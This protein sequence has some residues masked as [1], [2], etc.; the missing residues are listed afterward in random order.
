M[1]GLH[2]VARRA[3]RRRKKDA[4][5]AATA[6]PAVARSSPHRY[7]QTLS[8]AQGSNATNGTRVIKLRPTL[9]A[10]SAI[11]RN[12]VMGGNLAALSLL[13][14]PRSLLF[15]AS[16]NLFLL[17]AIAGRR[18]VTESNVFDVLGGGDSQQITLA[19]LQGE[20]WLKAVST[21]A[22]DLISLCLICRAIEPRVV[23]EIG[24]LHGYTAL[25]F[26]L[27]TPDDTIVHTLDLPQDYAVRPALT[28]T[29]MDDAHIRAGTR[30]RRRVFEGTSAEAKVVPLYGDSAAFDFSPYHGGVYFFF[31]DGAHSYEYVAADTRNAFACVRAGGVIAWHDFGRVGVNGVSRLVREVARS[32]EVH[33]VPG[34]S[35]AFT[36]V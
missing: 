2:E 32:R 20:T 30:A 4:W 23:F 1:I 17:H 29:V 24:T 31:L 8:P 25:H 36:V 26:A 6:P 14:D 7:P 34:G 22:A 3:P 35:L 27:N 9:H 10:A 19:N 18:G 21:Y 15:Y 11:V 12:L 16:E 28:T 33:A 13:R 5:L